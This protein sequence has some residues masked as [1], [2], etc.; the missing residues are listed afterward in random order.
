MEH[1]NFNTVLKY[2]Q[3]VVSGKKIACKELKQSCQRFLDDLTDP[4]YEIRYKDAEFCI[5]I[6]E[7]TFVSPEGR[8]IKKKVELFTWEK[9][10]YVPKLKKA[11]GLK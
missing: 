10:D 9:L 3:D 7:K 2:A 8:Q 6:I 11:F 5:G 4:R 1:K